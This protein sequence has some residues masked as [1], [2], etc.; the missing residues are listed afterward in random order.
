[1]ERRQRRRLLVLVKNFSRSARL[2]IGRHASVAFGDDG[3][4]L[5]KGGS[6]YF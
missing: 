3:R 1:M 4:G 6:F 5:G 2:D